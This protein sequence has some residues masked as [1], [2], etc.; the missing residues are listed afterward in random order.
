MYRFPALLLGLGLAGCAEA[1][2]PPARGLREY[3]LAGAPSNRIELPPELAEVSGLAFTGDGRLLAHGDERA[4][5]YQIALPAGKV[6]KRFAVGDAGGPLAGDFEDIQ[7]VDDRVFLVTSGGELVE[8]REGADGATVPVVRRSRGL[9]GA[10]EVEGLSW[11]TASSSMLL[12]CKEAKGS[13]GRDHLVI[14]A[15]NPAT[16]A[17]EPE[18]R[19]TVSQAELHRATGVKRFSGSA[20]VR[21]P[22]SGA[23]ILVAGPQR[24]FAEIDS[25]GRVL[26][27]GRLSERRHRQPEGLAIAPDLTLLISD[28]AVGRAATITGYASRR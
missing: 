20:M 4:V 5:I 3:D 15:V 7:V 6:V 2:T 26:G 9:R 18:P 21:H 16:G 24:A 22:R 10:C 17:F 11:D 1:Q 25:T 14:L 27:G 13:L 28:E 12:L 8:T 19:I 23:L